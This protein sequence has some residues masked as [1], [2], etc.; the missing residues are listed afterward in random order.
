MATAGIAKTKLVNGERVDI[1]TGAP[2]SSTAI[3]SDSL[4]PV[5][6]IKLPEAPPSNASMAALGGQFETAATQSKAQSDQFVKDQEAKAKEAEKA[7]ASSLQDYASSKLEPGKVA[8]TDEQYAKKGGVNDIQTE[9]D[10]INNQLLQ[11]QNALRRATE[12]VQTE[13][14]L[15]KGQVNQR[16]EE[17]TNKSLRKQ[18]DLSVIQQGVQGR[19][20]SAKAVADRYV[21]A[22]IETQTA[23]Q[24]YFKT[25]YEDNKELFNKE[26]S[27]AF[28]IKL[29]D[30][31]REIEKEADRMKEISDAAISMQEGGAPTSVVQQVLSLKDN[32]DAT[33]SDAVGIGGKYMGAY[34]RALKQLQIQNIQS[35]IDNRGTTTQKLTAS[36]ASALGYANRVL[37]SSSIIDDIGGQFVGA[38]S[39]LGGFLPN[40]LKSSERQQY[41]QAQ[42]NFINAV[43]RRESGAAI[44]PSEFDSA[45]NQYFPQP[46]DSQE[47]LIQKKQ[48]RDLVAQNLLR[49]GGKD[50]SLQDALLNDPLELGITSNSVNPLGI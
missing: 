28:E 12:K 18:A 20:D 49:E 32:P 2:F 21:S 14:G 24:D 48:N 34:D 1:N 43:L 39:M 22:Y 9:L 29:A 16:V 26:E 36:Q 30:R 23:R 17:I 47:V 11:E 37:Q 35:Q 45:R 25:V 13:A 41:E 50:T 46:G 33:L 19:Y 4:A 38:G 27:R 40:V 5:P 3:T 44:S 15:T 10:D 8:T 42:T 31:D 6:D 7:R